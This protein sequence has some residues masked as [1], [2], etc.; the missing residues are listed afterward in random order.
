MNPPSTQ[1][2]RIVPPNSCKV[3]RAFGDE[4]ALHLTGAET[5]GKYTLFT[6]VSPP[7]GG[8]PPHYHLNEDE[9]FFVLEGRAEFF[10]DGVWAEVPV[11]SVVYTPRGV[12]HTFRNAG[13][14]HLKLLVS[15]APS[16]FEVFFARCEEV[17][18]KPGPPDMPRIIQIAAEHGI[19]FV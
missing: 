7:G 5:D 13:Q 17:L 4:I 14:T 6:S 3:I 8:P 12:V 10:K 2:T 18:S 11:G 15:T 1:F 19:H 16:G 9:T